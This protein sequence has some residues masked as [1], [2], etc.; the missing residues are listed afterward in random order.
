MSSIIDT[1]RENNKIEGLNFTYHCDE[2][3]MSRLTKPSHTGIRP[4]YIYCFL[5][6]LLPRKRSDLEKC[7]TI[8]N[9]DSTFLKNFLGF[10][11]AKKVI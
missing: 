4:G 9:C 11:K 10:T 8:K 7:L 6:T 3:N 2:T 1:I 5:I